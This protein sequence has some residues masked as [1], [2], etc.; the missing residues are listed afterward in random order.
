MNI[1]LHGLQAGILISLLITV[2]IL[3]V[4]E[5]KW[6]FSNDDNY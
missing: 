6:L 4:R 1:F 2:I 5:I 3:L